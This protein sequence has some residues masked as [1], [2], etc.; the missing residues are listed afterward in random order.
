MNGVS[1]FRL[2]LITVGVWFCSQADA[3]AYIDPG[4]TS[5]LFQLLIGGLTAVAFFFGSIRRRV[6]AG[7]QW[8]FHRGREVTAPITSP[9][10]D[11]ASKDA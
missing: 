4:S 3:A 1:S 11:T 2:A 5:Y 6:K 9:P 10:K 7:W 8:L